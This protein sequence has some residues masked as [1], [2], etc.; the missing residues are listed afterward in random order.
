MMPSTTPYKGG[1]IRRA[2]REELSASI[3][4]PSLS[5]PRGNGAAGVGGCGG[6]CECV[7]S[8][9]MM[10]ARTSRTSWS[11]CV[12]ATTSAEGERSAPLP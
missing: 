6:L 10:C 11:V 2:L 5:P 1:E 9:A 7:Y 4:S 12:A 8:G 3:S